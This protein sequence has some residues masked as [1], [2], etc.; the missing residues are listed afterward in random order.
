MSNVDYVVVVMK[1]GLL[2][3]YSYNFVVF[4][5]VIFWADTLYRLCL[6]CMPS[7]VVKLII[8]IITARDS[9]AKSHKKKELKFPVPLRN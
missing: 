3:I 5:N 6:L 4:G 8:I 2:R 1:M 9:C 7:L